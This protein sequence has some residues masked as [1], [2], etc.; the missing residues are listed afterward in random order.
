MAQ[1]A[2]TAPQPVREI[3]FATDFS[4][5]SREAAS[6]AHAYAR[7]L[8]ARLHVLYVERPNVHV[9]V[10]PTLK[11]LAGE[12]GDGV[13]VVTSV[14]YGAAAD[15]IV[16]Y[17]QN[18][19][20][21]LIVVGTHGRTGATES[22]LGSVTERVART[23]PCPVV[24]VPRSRRQD[25][26]RGQP[27]PRGGRCAVCGVSS[28]DLFCEPCR[29]RLRALGGPSSWMAGPGS[30]V[31]ELTPDQIEDVLRTEIIGR[32]GCHA[33]GRTYVV[34]ISYVYR[35]NDIYMQADEGMKVRMMRKNPQVCF[36]VDRIRDLANWQSV[37]AWGVFRQLHGQEASEGLAQIRT[38]LTS[39]NAAEGTR[40]TPSYEAD[41]R[42]EGSDH[43]PVGGG[44][45]AVIA[46]IELTEKTGRFEQRAR[47]G[48]R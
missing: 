32:L 17:A 13:Q 26:Q 5:P 8:G 20:I 2:M 18:H 34:P 6:I 22:L 7:H 10:A 44:R 41:L 1:A 16:R 11:R 21:D 40:P 25:N 39:L 30:A 45:E 14:A 38:R 9:T 3:L 23:A 12:L 33:D 43:R 15:E 42:H 31:G 48:S 24:A 27:L 47:M 19:P 36:Q 28:D 29:A 4:D 35:D 46:R 37:I